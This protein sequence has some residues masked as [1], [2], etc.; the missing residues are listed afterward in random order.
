MILLCPQ[1]EIAITFCLVNAMKYALKK[2]TAVYK[3]LMILV[4]LLMFAVLTWGKFPNAVTSGFAQTSQIR[5]VNAPFFGGDEVNFDETAIFWFGQISPSENYADIRVGYNN[6]ELYLRI[7]I[8]DRLLWYDKTPEMSN[9]TD[10]DS[11]SLYLDVNPGGPNLMDEGI[12]SFVGQFNWWEARDLYQA[13]Y[14]GDGSGLRQ[15]DSG[16]STLSGWR[17]NAPNDTIDDRGWAITYHIPFSDFGLSEPPPVGTVWGL[18][19]SIHDRDTSASDGL[20]DKNW[21]ESMASSAPASWGEIAF[22]LP[23]YDAPDSTDPIILTI[24]QGLDGVNVPDTHVGGGTIC[25]DDVDFWDE[26]GDTNRAGE[27]PVNI[28]NQG[29]IADWP[30]FSK[31]YLTFPLDSIPPGKVVRSAYLTLHKAG[32]S[33]AQGQAQPS[34]I[35]VMMVGEEWGEDNITWNNAPLAT[36]N[37]ASL[38]VDPATFPGWPGTPFTWDVSYAA[39]QALSSGTPLRLALYE[40]DSAYHSGKYFITSDTG[41]WN[42]EARPTLVI[43]VGDPISKSTFQDVPQDHWAYDYIEALYQLGYVAGCANDPLRYCPDRILNRTESSVFIL[44]GNYGSLHDPPYT[45]PGFPTFVDVD[46]GYWGYGWIESLWTDGFTS[47]CDTDPL[48]YCPTREHTRAEACVFFLRIKNGIAFQ[49]P[50]AQGIFTDVI[51]SEWYASWVEA[52]YNDGL[53]P[54]CSTNPLAFCPED[55]LNR[56]WAAYMMIQAKNILVP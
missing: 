23:S 28:Q 42:E 35:Q 8:V 29:D 27:D 1:N 25:G 4:V 22:G 44:R 26:W 33:G 46:P 51:S 34:L 13:S 10:W 6:S 24:R 40:S 52:A 53:L 38:W 15:I 39:A 47:G 49:P 50:P 21:P 7:G 18:A 30:C 36:E 17:G 20:P 31:Y 54:A 45:P 56:A 32:H 19:L 37:V 3:S 12:Y 14:R 11:I 48:A 43:E 41:D 16:F 5:R 55:R 2:E 9:L